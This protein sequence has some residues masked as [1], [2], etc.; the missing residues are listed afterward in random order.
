MQKEQKEYLFPSYGPPRIQ[1]RD[2][3]NKSG[4]ATIALH[5][6]DLEF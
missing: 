1:T 5:S 2:S 6:I 3:E 4:N